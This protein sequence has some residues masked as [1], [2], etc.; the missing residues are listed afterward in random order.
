MAIPKIKKTISGIKVSGADNIRKIIGAK[1][2]TILLDAIDTS[3]E[4]RMGLAYSYSKKSRVLTIVGSYLKEKDKPLLLEII[5]KIFNNGGLILKDSTQE[6]INSYKEYIAT[7]NNYPI[8][9]FFHN[10]V[11]PDDFQA[12]KMAFYLRD[13]QLKGK[14]ITKYKRDI[15]ERFGERGANIANLCTA[16]YFENEFQPLYNLVSKEQFNDYYEIAV[17]KRARALFIHAR[18][19]KE[20]IETEFNQMVEKALNYHMIDFRV[21]GLGKNNVYAIKDFFLLKQAEPDE[22]YIFKKGYEKEDPFLVI[23]YVVSMIYKNEK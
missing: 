6:V 8:L 10:I 13:Q 12:L 1:G 16:G 18:M 9:H 3:E 7:N 17:G 14:N 19:S 5:K 21:H 4:A 11:P 23:E 15:R 22:R 2:V 20:N